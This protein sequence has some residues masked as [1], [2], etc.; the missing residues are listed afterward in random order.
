MLIAIADQ[1]ESGPPLGFEPRL[2]ACKFAGPKRSEGFA[3]AG[4][5]AR[6]SSAS[7]GLEKEWP[8]AVRIDD[9]GVSMQVAGQDL[10]IHI[11]SF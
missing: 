5:W 6:A 8:E 11:D 2:S 4:S 7:N 9:A 3:A 1:P 10:A